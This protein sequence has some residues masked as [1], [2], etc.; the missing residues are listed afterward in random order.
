LR[1]ILLGAPGSGKGTQ[2]ERIAETTR[3][4]HVSS[5]DLFRQAEKDGTELGKLAKSY[6]EKGL[7]VPDGVV[8][9]MVMERI[10]GTEKGFILDGFP[11][12]LEQAESVD[13]GL[14]TDGID[15]AVYIEVSREELLKRLSGRWICRRCQKPYHS[16]SSPPKVAGTC[17]VCGG[18]LYQR[19]DDT[20]ET[21]EKRLE[22]YFQQTAPLVEYYDK[23]EKLVKID[24]ERAIGE[25]SKDLLT[26][27]RWSEDGDN[28]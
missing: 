16:I 15:K 19:S 14:G 17:D 28:H 4:M 22:V 24:G 7:L 26:K 1:I 21:A 18:E 2:A 10:A 8:T 20:L 5:G 6:M 25:V 23:K 27:L 12:T 11:R 3:M 13:K 9:K